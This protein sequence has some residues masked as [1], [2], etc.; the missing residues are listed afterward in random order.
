MACKGG[1]RCE[2]SGASE[3]TTPA[4]AKSKPLAYEQSSAQIAK[5]RPNSTRTHAG[6]DLMVASALRVL[7]R[8]FGPENTIKMIRAQNKILRDLTARAH[9]LQMLLEWDVLSHSDYFDHYLNLNGW[10]ASRNP[11]WTE[12]GCFNLLAMKAGDE[13][14]EICCGDGFN[15]YHCY[16]Q[17]AGRLV[18]VDENAAAIAH[19]RKNH[20]AANIDYQICNILENI[21]G[22]AYDQ[23]IWDDA[24]AVF[25]RD[26]IRQVSKAIKAKLKN[27]GVFSGCTH[28]VDPRA[29]NLYPNF[30]SFFESK[31]DLASLFSADFENVKVFETIYPS[32]HNLYFFAADGVLPFDPGWRDQFVLQAKSS[33]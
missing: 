30:K 9:S 1:Y 15:S 5:I 16:S 14:L 2:R 32:R 6:V 31:E 8:V 27:S 22:G 13:V 11:M 33:D 3:E 4:R 17:R 29:S 20:S 12:R 25:S 24:I 23:V 26:E 18:A 7:V 19:A 10:H 28:I 21:P